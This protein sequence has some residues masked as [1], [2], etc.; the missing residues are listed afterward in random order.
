[1]I[2]F[3]DRGS[4]PRRSTLTDHLSN[5]RIKSRE[6]ATLLGWLMDGR[7]VFILFVL[8]GMVESDTDYVFRL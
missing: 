6:F 5:R 3:G 7:S 4:T 8:N 1:M 2:T